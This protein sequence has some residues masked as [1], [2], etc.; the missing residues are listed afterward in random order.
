MVELSMN[1]DDLTIEE[2]EIIEDILDAPFETAFAAGAKRGKAMRA[3]AF[4]TM[5][6]NDPN[7]TL[8]D[9]GKVSVQ[10]FTGGRADPPEPNVV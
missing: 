7:A 9:A 8:E 10:G 3:L 2:I 1:L 4:V 5:R 6:R